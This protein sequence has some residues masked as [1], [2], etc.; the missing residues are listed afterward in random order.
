M[1][2]YIGCYQILSDSIDPKH[3]HDSWAFPVTYGQHMSDTSNVEELLIDPNDMFNIPTQ[4]QYGACL[5]TDDEGFSPDYTYDTF[6]VKQE[7]FYI[8]NFTAGSELY[9]QFYPD[10]GAFY[11]RDWTSATELY[12]QFYVLSESFY[13][14]PWTTSEHLYSEFYVKTQ[15]SFYIRS[16]TATDWFYPIDW[17]VC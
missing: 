9:S 12:D 4:I 15:E 16:F 7:F 2:F 8:Q 14:R 10:P 13:V 5:W 17:T 3:D 1:S 11:V 6:Y